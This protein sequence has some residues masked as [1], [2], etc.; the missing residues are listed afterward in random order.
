MAFDVV[1]AIN[2]SNLS[3]W[4]QPEIIFLR[5]TDRFGKNSFDNLWVKKFLSK[6]LG[7]W[8]SNGTYKT[9]IEAKPSLLPLLRRSRWKEWKN[10]F[11][12]PTGYIDRIPHENKTLV[13][14]GQDNWRRPFLHICINNPG[15]DSYVCFTLFQRYRDQ[16]SV[17]VKCNESSDFVADIGKSRIS[18]QEMRTI[19]KRFFWETT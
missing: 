3:Q 4:I 13:E 11:H 16:A 1:A 15:P 7:L 6:I 10:L 14:L 12:G 9:I 5:A 18:D 2:C 8:K 17:W 19:V